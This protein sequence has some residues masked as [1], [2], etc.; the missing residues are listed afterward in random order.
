[1]ERTN[2]NHEWKEKDNKNVCIKCGK[3]D[4]ILKDTNHDGLLIGTKDNGSNYLV[5]TS[6]LRYF[7]PDEYEEFISKVSDKNK[8][9]FETLLITGARIEEAM[10]IKKS[11]VKLDNKYLILYTTKI[12]AKKQEKKSKQREVTLPKQ[13][14]KQLKTHI[15]NMKDDDYIF[16]NNKK[17]V[18][19]DNKQIKLIAD[20]KAKNVYQMMK[21]ILNKTSIED[22]WN[23][24]LHN[25]RKTTG[26]WL[27]AMNVKLEDICFRLG[28]DTNTYMKHY[29]ST[30]RFTN[31]HKTAIS[32][33][34]SGI[35]GI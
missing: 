12:K 20:K 27:K 33:K 14:L 2:C 1:M 11:H 17:L 32:N 15:Q 18:N 31:N 7:F 23:F 25:F 34:F 9:I 3:N 19:L 4:L 30:D 10:M 28:H 29:G 16:L 24:S 21:R 8:I 26:M 35:Y 5:R 13:Y 6:R 22:K